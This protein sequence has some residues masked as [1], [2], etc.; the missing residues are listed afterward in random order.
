MRSKKYSHLKEIRKE[1]GQAKTALPEIKGGI[2]VRGSPGAKSKYIF[3][4]YC[5]DKS[6]G[7]L[8]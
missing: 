3:C 7:Y 4:S 1:T 6:I 8:T 5:F 2:V